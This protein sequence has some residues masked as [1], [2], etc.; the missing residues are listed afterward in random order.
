VPEKEDIEILTPFGVVN[1]PFPK[2]P[3][4]E[5]PKMDD[6]RSKALGHALGED[7]ST[8]I[9]LVPLVGDI[10]ADVL[11]D[12]HASEIKKTLTPSEFDAYMENNKAAPSTVAMLR[13]FMEK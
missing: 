13:T 11:E 5:S 1:L 9:A 3:S 10:V 4:L 8:I 6:R 7:L 2:L 12:L